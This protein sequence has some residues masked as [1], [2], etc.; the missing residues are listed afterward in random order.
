M[1]R[2][3]AYCF[4]IRHDELDSFGHLNNAVCVKYMQEAAIQAST[5][6]GYSLQWYEKRGVAWVIRRL[7]VRY[8]LQGRY[9]EEL[10][11]TTWISD[12]SRS[13]CSRDYP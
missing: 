10:Q 3:F 11:V 13:A 12:C 4:R 9:G 7:E 6:A 8:Y 1:T 2:P 5:D